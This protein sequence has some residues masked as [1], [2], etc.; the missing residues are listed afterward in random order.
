MRMHLIAS[1][2]T[3]VG[4]LASAGY[5]DELRPAR[6]RLEVEAACTDGDDFGRRLRS[7]SSRLDVGSD[8]DATKVAVTIPAAS[9]GERA[10][11]T[12]RV[13]DSIRRVEGA[14]CEE[15]ADALSLVTVLMFDPA[16]GT[17]SPPPEPPV[18]APAAPEAA[19]PAP[20][21]RATI[22]TPVLPSPAREDDRRWA[23][24]MHAVGAAI[25]VVPIGASVF[26]EMMRG[27]DLSTL[28]LRLAATT[29][30]ASVE[31]GPRG[32]NMVWSFLAPEVCPLRVRVGPV[33]VFPCAGVA[34]GVLSSEPTRGAAR[35][36]SLRRAW[37][38]PRGAVRARVGVTPRLGVELEA[39]LDVPR[40]RDRYS[41]GDIEAY[42]IPAVIPSLGLGIAMA[43]P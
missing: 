43:L 16:A 33:S 27:R 19:P 25:D 2:A 12:M 26:G 1:I 42:R 21:A 23:I 36:R 6:L 15:I 17:P 11:G 30:S 3:G 24:G 20:L 31:L 13:G 8:E 7:H 40:V 5:A 39:G 4:L 37:F 10:F 41:F 38:A 18:T 34:V 29:Y 22:E 32:A 28:T 14:T 35:P 9:P